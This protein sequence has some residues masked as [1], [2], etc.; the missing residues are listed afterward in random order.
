M[1]AQLKEEIQDNLN[2]QIFLRHSHKHATANNREIVALCQTAQTI[3][4]KGGLFNDRT[5]RE[6]EHQ[7]LWKVSNA[8]L[9]GLQL[10]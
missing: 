6:L 5:W 7:I 2:S 4:E 8:E 1:W 10:A 9:N 3:T